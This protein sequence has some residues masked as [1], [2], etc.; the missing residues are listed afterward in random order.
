MLSNSTFSVP[1]ISVL[2]I[3]LLIYVNLTQNNEILNLM[4]V[5]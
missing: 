3:R 5:G 2:N 1:Y 4:S